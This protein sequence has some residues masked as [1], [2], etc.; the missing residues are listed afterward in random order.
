M[1]TFIDPTRIIKVDGEETHFLSFAISDLGIVL[2]VSGPSVI[3]LA[4]H[5][6]T[7]YDGSPLVLD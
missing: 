1:R 3:V 7:E 4:D 6:V 5:V 2:T